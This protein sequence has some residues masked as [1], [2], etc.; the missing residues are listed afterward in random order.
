MNE[1]LCFLSVLNKVYFI[2]HYDHTAYNNVPLYIDDFET[3]YFLFLTNVYTKQLRN[4]YTQSNFK[5]IL[6]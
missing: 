4:A 6:K 2:P 5:S 1:F 3:M